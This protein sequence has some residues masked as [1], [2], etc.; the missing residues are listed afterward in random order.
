MNVN[1][2]SGL[3]YFLWTAEMETVWSRI[4]AL[5]KKKASVGKDLH[6]CKVVIVTYTQQSEI[7]LTVQCI[8]NCSCNEGTRQCYYHCFYCLPLPTGV[9]LSAWHIFGCFQLLLCLLWFWS[10]NQLMTPFVRLRRF[11]WATLSSE[12]RSVTRHMNLEWDQGLLLFGDLF[13]GR[14]LHD[15]AVSDNVIYTVWRSLLITPNGPFVS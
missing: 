9:F 3:R 2:V 6:I 7:L 1:T 10:K 15:A 11:Y 12:P 5:K 13:W 8:R 14:E 4:V